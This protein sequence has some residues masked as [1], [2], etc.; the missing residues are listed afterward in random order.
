[1]KKINQIAKVIVD[2]AD[3][4][5]VDIEEMAV[6]KEDNQISLRI[7]YMC[8]GEWDVY[9]YKEDYSPWIKM[10]TGNSLED[11]GTMSNLLS[12]QGYAEQIYFLIAQP[13]FESFDW[14]DFQ[15]EMEE[16]YKES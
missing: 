3:E 9:Y 2:Y 14:D 7:S 13:D 15:E 4:L 12:T 11:F 8:G 5:G 1:M 6:C 16:E 10:H